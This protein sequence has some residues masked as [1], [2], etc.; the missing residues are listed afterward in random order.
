MCGIIAGVTNNNILPALVNGL[1]KLEYRGYDSAGLAVIQNNQIHLVKTV[2]K[3]VELKKL[4]PQKK[5][6]SNIGIGHTRWATHG[7][8]SVVNAHPHTTDRIALVHNGIIE[9]YKELKHELQGLGY[10]FKSETDT[11][12]VANLLDYYF[13]LNNNHIEAS[14]QTIAR[15]EGSFSLVFMFHDAELL[16]ATCKKTPLIL[17]L[18]KDA[19]Y[20]ASDIVAFGSNVGEVVYFEDEDAVLISLNSYQIFDKNGNPVKRTVKKSS[21]VEEVSKKDF[22]HFMLKEIYEQPIALER[23]I[24]KYLRTDELS[25]IKI[26]WQNIQHIKIL[27]C[28]TAYYSGLVAKY[29]L[30][31]LTNIAVDLEIASEFRYR[32]VA[33]KKNEVT[34]VI[35][36]SGETLDT[37]EA[38]KQAKANGQP[39]ISIVNTE[40]SSIGR[41]SDYVLPI[42]VGP[43]IGVASTKAFLGQLMVIAALGL[44]IGL[45]NQ[46]ISNNKV[47]ELKILL[48]TV[49]SMITKILLQSDKIRTAAMQ[50]K[51]FPSVLFI[52]RGNLY[53]IALEGSLK[54]K[55]LSDIHAEGYAGGELKHGPISLIDSNMPIVALMPNGSLFE[56]MFSNLQELGAR[57]G[58]LLTIVGSSNVGKVIDSSY[59][60]LEI[61]D[62]EEFIAPMIYSIPMQLLAY[63]TAD[64]KGN[65]IDQPRNL[66]KSVTVE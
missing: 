28:G 54:L 36:Q 66:A 17:G 37:L 7:V 34:I 46:N 29:W 1:E 65:D 9:N 47:E 30:E 26:D 43:E 51:D 24:D 62:C 20:I 5:L 64:L 48:S 27:A 33:R 6:D 39:I 21:L 4:L 22:P 14:K 10:G 63:Y 38:L 35:S 16:F 60:T 53:P 57:G 25:K 61:P 41:A 18:A 56:K 2:G 58:K 8:P 40:N 12:V 15:L 52:G 11:E 55:E 45:K 13:S 3:V 32:T 49:P 19:T 59:W 42:M 31:E 50:I 44:N 23:A